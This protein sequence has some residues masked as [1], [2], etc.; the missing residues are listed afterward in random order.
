M[1]PRSKKER[2]NIFITDGMALICLTTLGITI[3]N[4][5]LVIDFYG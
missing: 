2:R 4:Y 3:L 5:A 1:K